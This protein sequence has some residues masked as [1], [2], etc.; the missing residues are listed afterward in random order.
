ML[1]GTRRPA[2]HRWRERHDPVRTR[3]QAPA[4]APG[5]ADPTV[6]DRARDRPSGTRDPASA[7]A[8]TP[9][10]ARGPDPDPRAPSTPSPTKM[11]RAGGV[12][13]SRPAGAASPEPAVGARPVHRPIRSFGA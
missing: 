9:A 4:V 5:T 1:P 8:P 10:G 2:S 3:F 6:A 12:A 7:P 11:G 13:P